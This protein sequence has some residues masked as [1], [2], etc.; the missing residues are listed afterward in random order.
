MNRAEKLGILKTFIDDLVSA[1]KRIVEAHPHPAGVGTDG[2][3]YTTPMADE[4]VEYYNRLNNSEELAIFS[5]IC[6]DAMTFCLENFDAT[7]GGTEEARKELSE[8][9]HSEI[10]HEMMNRILFNAETSNE[11]FDSTVVVMF[12]RNLIAVNRLPINPHHIKNWDKFHELYG[13][14]ITGA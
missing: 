7:S 8:A 10:Q 13:S 4:W 12:F 1:H 6:S 11:F 3:V 14:L 9:F 2:N 5:G